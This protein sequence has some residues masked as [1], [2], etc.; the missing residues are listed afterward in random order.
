[1]VESGCLLS[2][3]SPVRATSGSNPDLSVLFYL[4]GLQGE[5]FP[6]LDLPAR[7]A[8]SFRLMRVLP[9]SS[10]YRLF[11]P[12]LGLALL[13]GLSFISAKAVAGTGPQ[14]LAQ[15]ASLHYDRKLTYA[16]VQS[17]PAAYA[18]R[19]FE[20]KGIVGG[21]V[22]ANDK[23]SVMLNLPDNN[24]V[25]LEIPDADSA[26]VRE[27]VTPQIRVLVQVGEGGSGN[28][29]P[30]KT[31]TLAHDSS[32]SA[33]E[34]AEAARAEAAAKIAE[35]RRK[36]QARWQ[37]QVNRAVRRNTAVEPSRGNFTR[38][39][40]GDYG[41]P[42]VYRGL[43]PRVQPLIGPYYN[44]IA[45]QNSRLTGQQVSQITYHL[46]YFA[47]RY[48]VDPRLVV[49][50]I[51]A[52]SS[53]D[54]NST[55]RTGAAGLGQLMPG[56]AK[57]L[58]VNNPYDPVQNLNGS[59]NYLRSRLDTFADKAMPDGGYSFEQVALAMAAYNA[60]T[61]AVKKYHG[62]PPYRETQAYVK[63]VISL[64]QQLCS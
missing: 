2:S 7:S 1:M 63:R 45:R 52:E 6:E 3:C 30:L 18:G 62:V 37:E 64:Y 5:T 14:Y 57:S 38:Q 22:T 51:I 10:R 28:V 56:T 54:P 44:F 24:A 29:V 49:A 43:S 9:V 33:A 8:S 58:G 46:L 47:D 26:V 19:V 27:S 32:V 11:L 15:R 48:N 21:M 39:V 34:Q 13:V 53:F 36:E 16:E 12:S 31:L 35:R 20:L 4:A 55:S 61:N 23:L 25:M 41:D 59:I 17:N 42:S 40:S 50:M 60:G